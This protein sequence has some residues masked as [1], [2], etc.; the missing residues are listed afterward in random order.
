[1]R[2]YVLSFTLTILSI[3]SI[4]QNTSFF[5]FSPPT[6]DTIGFH[7]ELDIK[8]DT[9]IDTPFDFGDCCIEIMPTF[10]GGDKALTKF[11]IKN[12]SYPDSSFKGGIEGTVHVNF[13]ID[14]LGNIKNLRII[15]SLS[16]DI[17]NEV[18]RVFSIMPKWKSGYN[19]CNKKKLN[20]GM[21]MPIHFTLKRRH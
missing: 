20:I 7:D 2:I 17:D 15:N 13:I 16:Y 18:L 6:V 9:K 8:N 3:N 1:M 11:L 12:I 19:A 10:P 14:T 4:G 21:T 5:E